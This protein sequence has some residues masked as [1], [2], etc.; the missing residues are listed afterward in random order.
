MQRLICHDSPFL[1]KRL[2]QL[3]KQKFS[4]NVIDKILNLATAAQ[5]SLILNEFAT[6]AGLD[7]VIQSQFGNFVLQNALNEAEKFRDP[8]HLIAADNNQFFIGEHYQNPKSVLELKE[9]LL[10]KIEYLLHS[11]PEFNA[12]G[13]PEEKNNRP[14]SFEGR[15]GNTKHQKAG[16]KQKWIGL[17]SEFRH[18]KVV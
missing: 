8:I 14:N 1:P 6:H 3:S 2:V 9:S 7:S 15:G 12:T 4:S 13:N 10:Q 5:L 16:I 11:S 17:V 18:K